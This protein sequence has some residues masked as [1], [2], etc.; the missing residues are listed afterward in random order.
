MECSMDFVYLG[1]KK[2]RRVLLLP[3][4][5]VAVFSPGSVSIFV[6]FQAIESHQAE[7]VPPFDSLF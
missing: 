4:P 1:Y 7:L 5:F 6:D 2:W 3:S